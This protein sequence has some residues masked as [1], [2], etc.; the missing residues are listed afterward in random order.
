M[1]YC[2][3]VI[4]GCGEMC[5]IIRRLSLSTTDRERIR[6]FDVLFTMFYALFP[7]N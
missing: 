7:I 5:V 6:V 1:A 3:D 4:D 2:E